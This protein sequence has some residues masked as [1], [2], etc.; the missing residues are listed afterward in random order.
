MRK[1][2]IVEIPQY[3]EPN[4]IYVQYAWKFLWLFPIWRY[5]TAYAYDYSYNRDFYR[6]GDA[7]EYI[8]SQLFKKESIITPYP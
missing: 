6:M 7:K 4:E 1:Y 2:R 5:V 8:N 3:K